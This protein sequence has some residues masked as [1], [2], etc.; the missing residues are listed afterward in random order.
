MT[1]F[2]V[3]QVNIDPAAA[4][5]ASRFSMPWPCALMRSLYDV[6]SLTREKCFSWF[7]MVYNTSK[8]AFNGIFYLSTIEKL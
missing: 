8:H 7:R 6:Q 3:F 2:I 5:S 4:P 1:P